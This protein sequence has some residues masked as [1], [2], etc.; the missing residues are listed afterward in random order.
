MIDDFGLLYLNAPVG[1]G[2]ENNPADVEALDERLRKIGAYSAPP[3]YADNP[4]RYATEPMIGALE[5]YQERNGLK[6]DGVANPGGPTERA[7]NNRLLEKPRGAGLLDDSPA[8]LAGTVGN[9]FEN[10]REDVANVQRRLGALNH[11]PEDPFDNPRGFIDEATTNGIK[12]FQRAKGLVEDGWLAPRGETERALD[13]AVSDL[14]RL[15]GRDWFDFA[16]RAGRAQPG[17]ATTLQHS[18][19]NQSP[20][21]SGEEGVTLTR[22]PPP[23]RPGPSTQPP[24]QRPIFPPASPPNRTRPTEPNLPPPRG[25]LPFGV[26]IPNDEPPSINDIPRA[27]GRPP[28]PSL[29]DEVK[30]ALPIPAPRTKPQ[31]YVPE[32]GSPLRIPII[33]LNPDGRPGNKETIKT[34]DEAMDTIEKECKQALKGTGATFERMREKYYRPYEGAQ[35]RRRDSSY[36][37]GWVQ[38]KIGDITIDFVADTYTPKTDTHPIEAE[39]RRYV[40]LERNMSGGHGAVVRV[41]KGWVLGQEVDKERLS[42]VVGEVCEQIKNMLKRGDLAPGKENIFIR[43]LLNDLVKPK[44]KRGLE[45]VTRPDLD[46]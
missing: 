41:P 1:K 5:R 13:N 19:G 36:A 22:V 4:Q 21:E 33:D 20:S 35:G 11:L 16:E 40:K 38:I 32:P 9:G 34:T 25:G 27:L 8:A 12:A 15:S 14:A 24:A 29:E 46:P 23:P 37:D 44:P 3:E 18:L 43:K 10:R 26:P 31:I 7:I 6:V 39:N 2:Q 17:F 28:Y 30:R 42:Q 45:P